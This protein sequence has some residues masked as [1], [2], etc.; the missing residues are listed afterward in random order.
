MRIEIY[1]PPRDGLVDA[2]VHGYIQATDEYLVQ[3]LDATV[4]VPASLV[5]ISPGEDDDDYEYDDDAWEG[6]A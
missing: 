5:S 1:D 4:H 3:V 6:N 2:K